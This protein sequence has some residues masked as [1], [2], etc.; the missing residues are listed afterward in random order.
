MSGVPGGGGRIAQ[1]DRYL[2]R[3]KAAKP[4]G[5]QLKKYGVHAG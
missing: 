1:L 5:S 2:G 4:L 3:E